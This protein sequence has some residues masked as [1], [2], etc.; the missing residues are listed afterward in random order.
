MYRAMVIEGG[1][2]LDRLAIVER[3]EADPKAFEVTLSMRAVSLNYRDVLMI[4]GQYNPRQPLPLVPLSDG[5][6]EVV[7]VGERVTGLA[8]GD[9]VCPLFCQ[10]YFAGEPTKEKIAS[11]LGGPLDG[12]L[13]EQMT[14]S[15][16]SV[17]KVPAG[18]DDAQAATLPCAALTAWNALVEQGGLVPGQTVLVQGTGGVS[19]FALQIAKAMGARVIVTSSSEAKLERARALGADHGIDYKKTPQWGKE[20]LKLT[21]DRGVDLVVEVGGA[22]T[23][24]ESLKAVRPGGTIAVIGMLA[25]GASE[26]NVIPILMRNI[27]VQGVFVGHKEA[28]VRMLRAF[29]SW[30]L[31]PVV[32]RVFP[33]TE[34]RAALDHMVAG[35]HLGKVALGF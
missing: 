9:R 5:V 30:S 33:W 1:F 7:A 16:E 2:G 3:N 35:A 19:T 29:D 4:R 12:V 28:M 20:A 15:A 11:T 22:G 14:L 18:L 25:G 21:D 31:K 13:R 23:L 8:K 17:V 10:R 27:R 32:D 24:G 6:G 34:A 26:V